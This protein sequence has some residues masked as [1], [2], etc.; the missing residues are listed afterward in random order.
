[1]VDLAWWRLCSPLIVQGMHSH[2]TRSSTKL[3]A[4]EASLPRWVPLINVHDVQMG[5]KTRN[6][7]MASMISGL[8]QSHDM[9]S[10]SRCSSTLKWT[11]WRRR[12]MYIPYAIPVVVMPV[13]TKSARARVVYRRYFDETTTTTPYS[14]LCIAAKLLSLTSKAT[15]YKFLLSNETELNSPLE[16]DTT[17]AEIAEAFHP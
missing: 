15:P 11:T 3:Q 7:E 2:T 14:M 16:H 13:T 9:W 1:V 8:H 4:L 12:G 6:C 5:G 17:H 10:N